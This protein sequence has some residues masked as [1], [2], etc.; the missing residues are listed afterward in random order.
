MTA[1]QYEAVAIW[2]LGPGRIVAEH[3]VEQHVGGRGQGHGR[4]GM[5]ALGRLDG[6]H[7]EGADGVDRKLLD[8]LGGVGHVV[9]SLSRR[10]VKGGQSHFRGENRDSPL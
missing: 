7:G 10:E 3:L 9:S 4:A 8:V 2:P 5:P 6:V 1:G